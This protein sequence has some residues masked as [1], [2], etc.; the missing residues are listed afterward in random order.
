MEA[1]WVSFVH[2]YH[3]VTP[4]MHIAKRTVL[5]DVFNAVRPQPSNGR[6]FLKLPS[7]KDKDPNS[8]TLLISRLVALAF[9]S[10]SPTEGPAFGGA[11]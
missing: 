2:G 11:R 7:G 3:A 1:A 6:G 5:I 10:A 9:C 4:T 8:M